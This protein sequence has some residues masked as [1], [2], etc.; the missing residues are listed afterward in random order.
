MEASSTSFVTDIP[1]SQLNYELD[2]GLTS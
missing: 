2:E 1:Q